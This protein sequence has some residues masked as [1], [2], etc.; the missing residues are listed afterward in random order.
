[1]NASIEPPRHDADPDPAG[2]ADSAAFA[3]RVHARARA[4]FR[5][6]LQLA[7]AFVAL[8]VL[9][10]VGSSL[11]GDGPVALGIRPRQWS[12][13]A[14]ILFAPL[15]HD[16]FAH[17]FA[18]AVP[19]FVLGTAMLYLYPQSARAVLPAV[20]A[21]PGIAVWL[22]GR[23]SMHLGASGLVYGL[24]AYVLAAGLIRRDRRALAASLLVCFLYGTL[25]WGVLPIRA[26]ASWETHLA[27]ALIS[28]ALSIAL[29]RR[30]RPPPRVYSWERTP[31]AVDL[32]WT[33]ADHQAD[34]TAAT[35]H[36]DD[37]GER[38]A[39]PRSDRSIN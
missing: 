3:E 16:G 15:L 27:A 30:D 14:G 34:W 5:L 32:A 24:F 18:N 20:Y 35:R 4:N 11:A 26:D 6:A 37:A 28:A 17:V 31:A 29:R 25:V 12:G 22:V 2:D 19:L 13:L 21:G 38:A 10:Q 39:E 1:M 9:L 23:D 36:R 7:G 33:A 8:I